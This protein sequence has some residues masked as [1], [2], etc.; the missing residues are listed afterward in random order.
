MWGK[1][2]TGRLLINRFLKYFPWQKILLL[3]S[4]EFFREP[5]KTLRQVFEFVGVD[6][7]FKVRNLK[8]CNVANNKS[9]VDPHIYKYLTNYFLPHNQAL[10]ELIG[11]R[12][13]W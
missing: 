5:H 2:P 4:E 8:P 9:Q 7:E 11:K 3:N 10:Y 1:T 12:Y 6:P 13:T